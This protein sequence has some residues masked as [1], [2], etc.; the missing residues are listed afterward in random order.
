MAGIK[1][2][3]GVY[4]SHRLLQGARAWWKVLPWLSGGSALVDLLGN[5]PARLT[6]APAWVGRRGRIGGHGALSLANASNQYAVANAGPILIAGTTWTIAAAI[7]TTQSNVAG[8]RAVYAER[9]SSGN[10]I[11]KLET[12]DNTTPNGT[13]LTYRNDGG[14]LLQV[15]LGGSTNNINDGAWHYLAATRLGTAVTLYRDGGIASTSGTWSG[16]DNFTNATIQAWIG[17]DQG[18]TSTTAWNGQL[19]DIIILNRAWSAAEV[20]A[21]LDSSQAGH[22]SLLRRQEFAAPP[23]E[24]SNP[25]IGHYQRAFIQDVY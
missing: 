25:P 12:T 7:N 23:P 9:G 8:G 19:D 10:D 18:G 21:W 17:A 2:A 22:P 3:F 5:F 20:W 1:N 16:T 4:G 11:L 24:V 14:T 15:R 6:N 13:I